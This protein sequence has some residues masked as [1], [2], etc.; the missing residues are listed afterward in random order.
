M[1]LRLVVLVLLRTSVRLYNGRVARRNAVDNAFPTIDV[2]LKLRCD[3]VPRV[4]RFLASENWVGEMFA[5]D[6][7]AGVGL[8]TDSAMRVAVTLAGED[9]ENPHGVRGYCPISGK[10]T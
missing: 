1:L 5:G 8:P 3:L 10:I 9:R 4:A 7:L 2:Q 6:R